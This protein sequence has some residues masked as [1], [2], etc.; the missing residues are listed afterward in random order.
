M[1][2]IA[3]T[4]KNTFRTDKVLIISCVYRCNCF[5][6]NSSKKR[7]IPCFAPSPLPPLEKGEVAR[8]IQFFGLLY[9]I[10]IAC[11]YASETI[12]SRDGGDCSCLAV[13]SLI[14]LVLSLFHIDKCI[15]SNSETEKCCPTKR[16]IGSILS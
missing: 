16:T 11:L 7:T 5:N 10:Q 9:S 8:L 14:P 3:N 4:G 13:F 1:K 12:P 2:Y 6:I 15:D